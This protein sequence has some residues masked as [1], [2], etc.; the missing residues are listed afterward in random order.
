MAPRVVIV[1]TQVWAH[2]RQEVMHN[3]EIVDYERD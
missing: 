1:M 3:L 2:E